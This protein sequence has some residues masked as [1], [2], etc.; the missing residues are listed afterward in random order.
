MPLAFNLIVGLGNPTTKYESTRHNAGFW[1]VDEFV[2][3][4]GLGFSADARCQGLLAQTDWEGE[5]LYV[6]KPMQYMNR[7]GGSVSALA[8]YYKIAPS[9]I[10][11]AH[12]E[13]D[14]PPGV[15]KLK[16][17]GGHG[18]HNGLRDIVAKLSCGDLTRVRLGIGHPGSRDEVVNFVLDRPPVSE[19][20]LL[21]DA[22][23]RAVDFM[24]QIIGGKLDVAMNAL[25]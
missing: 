9:K 7:S 20:E 18:G 10:L 21:R 1:F 3:R 11:I 2:R 8:N 13:L 15:V 17:G 22:V 4:N 16:V 19:R 24:P 6:L 25:H 12:D 5:K 14:F 23:A